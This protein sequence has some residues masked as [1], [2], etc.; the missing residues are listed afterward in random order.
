LHF[1][2]EIF[3]IKF[4][5]VVRVP[6]VLPLQGRYLVV[7]TD[8]VLSAQVDVERLPLRAVCVFLRDESVSEV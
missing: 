5:L 4:E 2:F 8:S 3:L 7:L 1:V 6:D